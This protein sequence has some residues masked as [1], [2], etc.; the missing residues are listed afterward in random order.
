MVE[1]R[2]KSDQDFKEGVV[3]LIREGIVNLFGLTSD[4]DHSVRGW[5]GWSGPVGWFR[6]RWSAR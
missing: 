5:G 6:L 3:R 1:S 4:E 2:R